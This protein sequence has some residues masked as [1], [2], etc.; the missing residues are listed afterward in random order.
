MIDFLALLA[1]LGLTWGFGIALVGALYR[2]AGPDN[3][4]PGAWLVGC[5]WF[6]GAF[7]TTLLMRAL[8]AAGIPLAVAS[9]GVPMLVAT[10]AAAWMALR[11]RGPEAGVAAR[12]FLG[13]LSGRGLEGWQRAVW[14]V[15]VAW[16]ALRFALLFAEVW[17]RPLYPW[18]AWT[19]WG[20]KARVWFEMRSMVP[21][22]SGGEWL[23]AP[24]GASLWYDAA[25]HY[26]GTMPLLQVWS[27]LL[28]GR[29]DDAHANLPWWVTGVALA[30]GFYGG[31]LLLGFRR[32]P[33]L[34][35]AAI[36]LTLPIVD[37]HIALAGYADLPLACYLT[38]GTVAGMR[39]IRTR[40]VADA[41]LAVVLLAAMVLV[42]NPGKAW[43]LALIPAFVAAAVPRHGVRIAAASVALAI[44]ALL[45]ATRSG[46]KL[47]GYQFSPSFWMPWGSLFDAYFSF[48]NWNLLWYAAVATLA[49]GR[50]QLFAGEAAPYTLAVA[51]GLLFLFVGLAFTNA[52]V[53]VEDQST[54]NRA[55]LHLAPLV[56]VWILVVARAS[57]EDSRTAS[58][59]AAPPH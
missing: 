20:T 2:V 41:M 3:A 19:Q 40:S 46:V 44:F 38:L 23:A 39:A 43:L 37:V 34:A 9:I 53:W 31:L 55:T 10:L 59:T 45:V 24:P 58:A 36:V 30:I 5:G 57:L 32:I 51:G 49:V 17:W 26:P 35:G 7:A 52:W 22:V 33:A 29:W 25:P 16:L 47:L 8:S 48:A 50:R 18:D 14:I 21:F 42:K 11:G 6:V 1:G 12:R 13:A 56:V 4:P 15:I 27:A 54:I 28:V